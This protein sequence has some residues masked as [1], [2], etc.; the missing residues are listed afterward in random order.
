NG[1]V[2][3]VEFSRRCARELL[4]LAQRR[5]NILPIVADARIPS[6][7]RMIVAPPL[8]D[9]IISD[10]AQPDQARIVATNAKMFLKTGGVVL[11]SIKAA[12]VDS[13]AEPEAVFASEVQVLREMGFK[14]LEQISLEPYE[15]AHAMV[16]ARYEQVVQ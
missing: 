15:R 11:I 6:S 5:A 3:A 2:Y 14:P 8:V 7:Y 9:V 1:R 16:I 4:Y 13:T 10:V 12:C